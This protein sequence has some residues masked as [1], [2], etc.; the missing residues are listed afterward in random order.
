MNYI[1]TLSAFGCIV[2]L[3]KLLHVSEPQFPSLEVGDNVSAF[4]Q[5]WLYD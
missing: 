3:G 1:Y 5:A 2:T 4:L